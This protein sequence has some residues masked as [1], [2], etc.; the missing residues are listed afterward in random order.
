MHLSSLRRSLAGVIDEAIMF[1]LMSR[2]EKVGSGCDYCR[3]FKLLFCRRCGNSNPLGNLS[4]CHLWEILKLQ[5]MD[6]SAIFIDYHNF[7]F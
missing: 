1:V 7:T 6:Y 2:H 4:C 3:W 5:L